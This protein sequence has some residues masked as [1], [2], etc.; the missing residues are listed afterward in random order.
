M[1][2]LDEVRWIEFPSF[3]DDRGCLTSIEEQ[4]DI[5][6][7]LKRIFYM[8]KITTD[9]GGHAHKDTD[10]VVI[11]ISGEFKIKLFDGLKWEEYEMNNATKGLY[12]PRMVFVELESFTQ[13]AVCLVL[14]NTHYDMKMSLRT[15]QEYLEVIN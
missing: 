1:S 3:H 12:I 5:P 7:S 2:I 8:H 13:D 4:T 9:R 10:Q 11:A 6:I 14:A 15:R